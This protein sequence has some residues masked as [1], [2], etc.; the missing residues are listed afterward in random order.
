MDQCWDTAIEQWKS[1]YTNKQNGGELQML[2][3]ISRRQPKKE[4]PTE[5][6]AYT[7]NVNNST[8]TFRKTKFLS[9]ACFVIN[10]FLVLVNIN[11]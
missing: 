10:L 3:G 8:Q 11:V 9:I 5:N 1:L 2:S 4:S 6:G 7:C